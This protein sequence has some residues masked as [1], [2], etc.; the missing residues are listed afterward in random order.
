MLQQQP[1]E[2]PIF[3]LFFFSAVSVSDG[4]DDDDEIGES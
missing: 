3:T 1:E 4:D 2:S